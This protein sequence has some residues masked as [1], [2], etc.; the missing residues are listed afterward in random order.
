MPTFGK[1]SMG[2]LGSAHP[3]LRRLFT[4]VVKHFDCAVLEGHR[5]EETQNRMLADGKSQLPWPRSK[6][7]AFPARAVDV[8]PY[9]I[10]WSDTQRMHLFAGFVKGVAVQLGIG[11]RWGGDWDSDTEVKDERF[12][13]LPHFELVE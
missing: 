13:D 7:N 12:R 1:R 9:P 3:D 2:A 5:D 11:I 6:H 4:E 8:V 10:D